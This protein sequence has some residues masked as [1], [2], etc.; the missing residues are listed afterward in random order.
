MVY[1][2][3]QNNPGIHIYQ[4]GDIMDMAREFLTEKEERGE[5]VY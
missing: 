1:E 2:S 4:Y 3:K 5:M